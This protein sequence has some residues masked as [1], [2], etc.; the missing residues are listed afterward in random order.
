MTTPQYPSLLRRLGAMFYD[1]ILVA[2]VSLAYGA[3]FL[4]AKVAWF[5]YTI[6][7]DEK[8]NLGWTGFIGWLLLL[9]MYFSF[10]WVRS[11]QTLGMKTWRITVVDLQGQRINLRTALLRW[12]LAWISLALAGIGYWWSIIDKDSQT[13]H[14][15][16][17]K[18]RTQLIQK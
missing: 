17:S 10:F 18:S 7:A 11:G 1:T 13:L 14:D 6:P 4:W 2:A 5:D 8:A 15:L 9:A 3:V 16:I 12:C